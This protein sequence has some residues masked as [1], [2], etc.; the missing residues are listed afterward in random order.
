MS[1]LGYKVVVQK[2]IFNHK[3]FKMKK[4]DQNKGAQA[5]EDEK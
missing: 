3:K 5:T 4:E 1:T 2:L